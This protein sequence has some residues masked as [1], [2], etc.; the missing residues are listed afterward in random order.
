MSLP[1]LFAV[2]AV[3]L[4]VIVLAALVV[5]AHIA[6]EAVRRARE[7]DLP[8]LLETSSKTLTDL[9]GSLLLRLGGHLPVPI[10]PRA[11]VTVAV[12]ASPAEGES[13]TERGGTR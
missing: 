2:I 3:L 8:Q 6:G 9:L 5:H 11:S 13:T 12:E 4:V 1:V 7:E 10:A